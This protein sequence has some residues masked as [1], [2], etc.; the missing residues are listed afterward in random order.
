MN[1]QQG[2]VLENLF[3]SKTKSFKLQ[4]GKLIRLRDIS[5]SP[6][7][8]AFYLFC[9]NV[10]KL[11]CIVILSSQLSTSSF[12]YN[13]SLMCSASMSKDREDLSFGKESMSPSFCFVD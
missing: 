4:K 12:N 8:F 13:I 11:L 7:H 9:D 2:K 5:K 1:A 3:C 6:K 10:F